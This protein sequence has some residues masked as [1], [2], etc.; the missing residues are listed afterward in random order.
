MIT[1]QDIRDD[2]P[3]CARP[4]SAALAKLRPIVLPRRFDEAMLTMIVSASRLRRNLACGAQAAI[5]T[6][7]W[8]VFSGLPKL[9]KPTAI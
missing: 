3:I 2:E 9:T 5:I 8:R 6:S 7:L 4:F 1:S